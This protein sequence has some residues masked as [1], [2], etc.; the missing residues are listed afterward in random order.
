M[1][2]EKDGAQ[3]ETQFKCT[4][5]CFKCHPEQRLYC[6][7]QN[8]YDAM[9]T[10]EKLS[11]QVSALQEDIKTLKARDKTEVFNIKSEDTAQ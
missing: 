7:A 1:E 2:T 8:A 4:G 3:Q 5:D 11:A 6:S 9:R 10:M